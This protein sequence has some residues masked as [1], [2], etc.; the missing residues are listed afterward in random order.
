M[1]MNSVLAAAYDTLG[2]GRAQQEE[3]MKV[4]HL[5]LFAKA[6]AANNIDLSSESPETVQ[7]LYQAF[8]QKL[9]QEDEGKGNMPPQFA[10]KE[11]EGSEADKEEDKK[12]EE[13]K[14]DEKKEAAARAEFAKQ[15]EWNQKK[16]EADF[17]GR[18]MAHSFWQESNEISKAASAQGN[19]A[20]QQAAT[21]APPTPTNGTKTASQIQAFDLKAAE[22]A[23]KIASGSGLNADEVIQRLNA[24]LTLGPAESEKIAHAGNNYDDALGIRALELLEQAKYP[25]D[26]KQV[27]GS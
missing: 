19:G 9:A 1:G 13:K 3:Q 18:L 5:D 17:L 4:A 6:A 15:A 11:D 20:S 10:K 22:Q 23:V 7:Q 25:V 12:E 14:E 26:W 21:A 27:L 16:A 2:A 24:V 8:S